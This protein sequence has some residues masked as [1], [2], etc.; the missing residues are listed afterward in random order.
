MAKYIAV[1]A[2]DAQL[3]HI[4]DT[5]E[6]IGLVRAYAPGDSYAAVAANLLGSY[7][8]DV[9]DLTL[10]DQVNGRQIAVTEQSGSNAT[11]STVDAE[12]GTATS[13]GAA[14]LTDTVKAWGVDA[15]KGRRVTITAGTGA[16]Q[17]LLIISNTATQLTVD[18]DWATQPDNTSEYQ[19][20]DALHCVLLDDTGSAVKAVTE[21]SAANPLAG[22]TIN[23]PLTIGAFNIKSN[24]PVP[25]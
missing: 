13:G 2:L 23:N 22:V 17:A 15:Q 14:T 19:I 12:T 9:G 7:P 3:Q 6:T 24:Q 16:G 21:E 10:G 1:A 18:A 20:K 8:A 4:I 25:A 5:T 11:A